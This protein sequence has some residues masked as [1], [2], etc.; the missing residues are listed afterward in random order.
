M[1]LPQHV[2]LF[3]GSI[4]DNIRYTHETMT[5]ASVHRILNQFG[6]SD[7]LKGNAKS[8][9]YLHRQVGIDGSGVSGGQ[10]QIIILM[11]TYIDT[12]GKQKNSTYLSLIHI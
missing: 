12:V 2:K 9:T 3:E 1:Y 5:H 6:V 11:R 8:S 10:K 4:L 7:L